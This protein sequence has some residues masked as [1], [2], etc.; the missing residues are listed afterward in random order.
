[1]KETFDKTQS[2][3]GMSVSKILL[4]KV[5]QSGLIWIDINCIYV[6]DDKL[7]KEWEDNT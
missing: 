6:K 1:M 5:L 7:N 3:L 2:Y 4:D